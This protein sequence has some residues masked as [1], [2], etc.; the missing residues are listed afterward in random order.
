MNILETFLQKC[1]DD[2]NALYIKMPDYPV[3]SS[4]Y[5][6]YGKKEPCLK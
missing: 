4:E 5:L 2:D 1:Y 6:N 3:F